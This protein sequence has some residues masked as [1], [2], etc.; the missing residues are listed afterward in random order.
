MA[1]QHGRPVDCSRT[2][3]ADSGIETEI[4]L[5][6]ARY[7]PVL[8][9]AGLI[10]SQRIACEL[11]RRS[12]SP[13]GAVV[14]LDCRQHGAVVALEC[15]TGGEAALGEDGLPN[16]LLLQE[17]HALS[18]S[19]QEALEQHMERVLLNPGPSPLVRIVASSS[20]PLFD[21]VVQRSFR[22][23]LYYRL[24]MVHIVVPQDGQTHWSARPPA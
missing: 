12:R 9:S 15:L 4:Q 2:V 5:A 23:R 14:V 11:D 22:E 3:A 19:D 20:V 8:I 7:V 16:T 18:A 21:R 17:V 6:A 24:S 1:A 10:A 13:R